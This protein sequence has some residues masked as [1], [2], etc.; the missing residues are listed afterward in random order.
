MPG[1][2][3]IIDGI[4]QGGA[5]IFNTIMQG[6]T[7]QENRDF[8]REQNEI[9]RQREDTAH[10]REVQDL[11]NAG[12]SPLA[13]LNGAQA[14]QPIASNQEAP[15][16]DLSALNDILAVQSQEK[17]AEEELEQRKKEHNENLTHQQEML[18]E[19]KRQFDENMK[20]TKEIENTNIQNKIEE[21]LISEERL[22][23]QIAFTNEK[24]DKENKIKLSEMSKQEYNQLNEKWSYTFKKNINV[25]Y[26]TYLIEKQR[27]D[28]QLQ[29]F[30]EFFRGKGV[31]EPNLSESGSGSLSVGIG[32]GANSAKSS[33]FNNYQRKNNQYYQRSGGSDYTSSGTNANIGA[34]ASGAGAWQRSG[35]WTKQATMTMYIKQYCEKNNI[36]MNEFL[37]FPIYEPREEDLKFK[38]QTKKKGKWSYL[39]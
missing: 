7:A 31:Q 14:S 29:K 19:N 24:A 20:L 5:S 12:L 11:E 15:Q 4:I 33:S 39:D 8:E 27:F 38:N 30:I 32:T 35:E 10:V 23:E 34:S 16:L 22:N 28:S 17:I 6:K 26:T 18:E 21:F 13:S 3:N 1:F 9:T 36:K 2:E 25:D 37:I